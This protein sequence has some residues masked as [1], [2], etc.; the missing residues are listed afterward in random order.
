M[1]G[2]YNLHAPPEEIADYLATRWDVE[3]KPRFNLAPTETA[4]VIRLIDGQ[5]QA[6]LM[7]WGLVPFWADDLKVGNRMINARAETI[8]D[9][10]T[11]SRPFERRRC[12]VP[13]TGFYEWKKLSGKDKQTYH[14]TMAD[15]SPFAFAG[16]WERW[17]G[18]RDEPLSEPVE[19]FTI[20]TTE[21]NELMAGIH[22]R[23]PAILP[24]EHYDMWLDPTFRAVEALQKML[25]PY[26]ADEMRAVPVGSYVNKP[27]N[28]GPE[29]IQE[30]A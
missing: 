1:C 23:M 4:P 20:I 29:C 14:I 30:V 19:S 26:P 27:G 6:A 2:R 22:D 25:A 11:F 28:E 13:A 15:D 3:V 10:N 8:L 24:S 5:R 17:K 9:K 18:P 16:L 12:L 7:R 21:P